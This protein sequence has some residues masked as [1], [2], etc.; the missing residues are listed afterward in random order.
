MA[1]RLFHLAMILCLVWPYVPAKAANQKNA[2]TLAPTSIWAETPEGKKLRLRN[3][4]FQ[5]GFQQADGVELAPVLFE[6]LE[7]GVLDLLPK[8]AGGT[9]ISLDEIVARTRAKG[10]AYVGGV[11]VA[12]DMQGWVDSKE[13]A[14]PY[15]DTGLEDQY[16]Q[17]E[18]WEFALT[19]EGEIAL[20]TLLHPAGRKAFEEARNFVKHAARM[21]DLLFATPAEAN[22]AIP[23][24]IQE[25]RQ[26][27]RHVA[28]LAQRDWDLPPAKHAGELAVR[29][30]LIRHLNGMILG[31]LMVAFGRRGITGTLS[32]KG[33][34]ALADMKGDTATFEVAFEF[35]AS[36]RIAWEKLEQGGAVRAT[37]LGIEALDKPHL[38]GVPVSYDGTLDIAHALMFENPDMERTVT[39]PEGEKELYV[40]RDMNTWGSGRAHTGYF[41]KERPSI[42]RIFDQPI[43]QQPKAI[44][45]VGSGD[46]TFLQEAYEYILENTLRGQLIKQ[47]SK[48]YGL[49]VAGVDY[50][51]V[52]IRKTHARLSAAG[53]DE[54]IAIWGDVTDPDTIA[55]DLAKH[56]IDLADSLSFRSS[57]D[58]N[59]IFKRPVK[60][61]GLPAGRSGLIYS[62][63][64]KIVSNSELEQNLVEHYI[65]WAK[66]WKKHGAIIIDLHGI[67]PKDARKALGRTPA[68]S[69]YL[70]HLLSDQYIVPWDVNV[71]ALQAAG[72]QTQEVT[73]QPNGAMPAISIAFIKARA[74]FVAPTGAFRL[75]GTVVLP[76]PLSIDKYLVA[77]KARGDAKLAS[78]S[79]MST[80]N[81]RFMQALLSPSSES[82][83]PDLIDH[84][85]RIFKDDLRPDGRRVTE[86]VTNDD[87]RKA[88]AES[89]FLLQDGKLKL[90]VV[91]SEEWGFY[92]KELKTDSGAD[93]SK[94]P[95]LVRRIGND[96]F[97]TTKFFGTFARMDPKKSSV[98]WEALY[99]EALEFP[100]IYDRFGIPEN[101]AHAF[102]SMMGEA[103]R[104]NRLMGTMDLALP[105]DSDLHHWVTQFYTPEQMTAFLKYHPGVQGRLWRKRAL[106]EVIGKG[107]LTFLE[108]EIIEMLARKNSVPKEQ[109]LEDED[110]LESFK[111]VAVSGIAREQ[112]DEVLN[113]LAVGL[114]DGLRHDWR[115]A[116]A[117]DSKLSFFENMNA[118]ILRGELDSSNIVGLVQHPDEAD[119]IKNLFEYF[120]Q[121]LM[122]PEPSLK[123]R[124]LEQAEILRAGVPMIDFSKRKIY[125]EEIAMFVAGV[126][127]TV[128]VIESLP[129]P[130]AIAQRIGKEIE[131]LVR[132]KDLFE[133]TIFPHEVI[134]V[135]QYS[136]V[137]E[138]I[139]GV[140]RIA[141]ILEDV[142]T[143]SG[144]NHEQR[145][146]AFVSGAA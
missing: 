42:K 54:H 126:G 9:M 137:R 60:R 90:Y 111:M 127:L 53:I 95:I 30:V 114:Y 55:A 43:E 120:R 91:P 7:S 92:A 34:L 40:D 128:I 16:P 63:R 75:P 25:G 32:K 6:L 4:Y 132:L 72:L 83:F 110:F 64:G 118:I 8:A 141:K 48:R 36:P 10:P 93:A 117:I 96:L 123:D 73:W 103:A 84:F 57:L 144:T 65:H 146:E 69:Y 125:T 39:T 14:L 38:Y 130:P 104:L 37:E 113:I 109:A 71:A 140:E 18:K 11:L 142:A 97:M 21:D 52:S 2:F 44:V 35:L 50:N 107:N 85:R 47:D 98:F 105:D 23:Q 89:L 94:I 115:D 143:A 22:A 77:A 1:F 87:L 67:R 99:H 121:F 119:F 88:F 46:G 116:H 20:A 100:A 66:Y 108:D 138:F 19:P 68:I 70:T 24:E 27:F 74:P 78:A 59:R 12:M 17:T 3:A 139:R 31:P 82:P 122:G 145:E 45:D 79:A 106:A 101:R 33:T 61:T 134:P 136:Y 28:E 112:I 26:A 49:K 86:G 58:H 5:E 133:K 56:G 76:G 15:H 51:P 124:L 29:D 80:F 62:R 131:Q 129:L 102:A 41:L 13:T 81:A 135:S